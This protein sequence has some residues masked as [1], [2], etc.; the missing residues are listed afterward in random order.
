M[1]KQRFAVMLGREVSEYTEVLVEANTSEEAE[2][3][4]LAEA[5]KLGFEWS[6]GDPG[7]EYVISLQFAEEGE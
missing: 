7:D 6:K 4:A 3:L 1:A 5:E 2:E